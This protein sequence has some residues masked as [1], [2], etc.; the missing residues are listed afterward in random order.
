M[1]LV[2]NAGLSPLL[3]YI[4]LSRREKPALKVFI[5]KLSSQFGGEDKFALYLQSAIEM[6]DAAALKVKKLQEKLFRKWE[7]DKLYPDSVITK[8]FKVTTGTPKPMM[9]RIV[10][11]YNTFLKKKHE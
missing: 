8:I 5:S 4:M 11:R 9:S 1:G 10:D 2:T 7:N 3:G 6:D